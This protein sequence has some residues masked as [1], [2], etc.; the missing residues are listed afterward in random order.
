[1]PKIVLNK[2]HENSFFCSGR[3]SVGVYI[4]N[5]SAI[6]ID[7]GIDADIAKDIDTAIM[8][9]GCKVIAIINTHHHADHC[10]GNAYFQ[11]RYP[12]LRIFATR[13]EA[14]FIENPYLE[15]FCFCGQAAPLPEL[16]N[17]FLETTPSRVTH[18]IEPYLDQMITIDEMT[19]R[20]VTLPGHTPGSIGIITPDNILYSGD[21]I[22]GDE[23]FNKHGILLYSDIGQTLASFEKLSSLTVQATVLYHGGITHKLAELSKKHIARI[24]A[25]QD[26]IATFVKKY[27]QGICLDLL[28]AE[29]MQ[30]YQIPNTTMQYTL[31]RTSVQAYITQLNLEQKVRVSVETGLLKIL[32]STNQLS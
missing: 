11:K 2:V 30:I 24:V 32:G 8:E 26:T 19:F 1:M 18:S 6:L 12:D 17:K 25:T 13:F 20:M 21:A 28:T 22:F 3:C 5:G 29:V 27:P 4:N 10:G 9:A 16:R 7:S 31:T 14:N 23:A 15:T